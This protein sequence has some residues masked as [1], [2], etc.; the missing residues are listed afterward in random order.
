MIVIIALCA[1][2]LIGAIGMA[3]LSRRTRPGVTAA[4]RDLSE[5]AGGSRHIRT[6]P[7]W[8]DRLE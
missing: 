7:S 3:L 2:I 4:G 8:R 1:G 6:H 5:N